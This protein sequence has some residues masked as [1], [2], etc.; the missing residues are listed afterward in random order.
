[1]STYYTGILKDPCYFYDIYG[2]RGSWKQ[3]NGA[4]KGPS[5]VRILLPHSRVGHLGLELLGNLSNVTQQICGRAGMGGL[6]QTWGSIYSPLCLASALVPAEEQGPREGFVRRDLSQAWNIQKQ[7]HR[8]GGGGP[9]VAMA[10]PH[11]R[12]RRADGCRRGLRLV[13]K[14]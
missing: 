4:V 10:G 2:R 1:M 9:V 13:S 14:P 5:E 11:R 8:P 3:G 12:A 7:P 6:T